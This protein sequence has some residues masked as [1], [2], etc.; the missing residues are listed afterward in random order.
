MV[1]LA[2]LAI[3]IQQPEPPKDDGPR[4]TVQGTFATDISAI[5]G[6]AE[7]RN[8]IPEEGVV[9]EYALGA[10]FHASRGLRI[11]V[12]TCVGCHDFQIQNAFGEAELSESLTLRVG[13]LPVPFGSLSRRVNP[14]QMESSTKPLPYIMGGMVGER[15]FN[16]GIVPAP[17]VDNGAS[18]QASFW[19]GPVQIGGEAAVLRGFKGT[20][21]DIDY[22]VS[23]LF[24]DNNG[25]PAGS[26]RLSVAVGLFTLGISG[27]VG[28]YDVDHDLGYRLA[29]VDLQLQFGT[30]SLRAEALW[31]ETEFFGAGL[32]EH[33]SRRRAYVVE[34]DGPIADRWR[35]FVLHDAMEMR[36]LFATTAGPLVTPGAPPFDEKSNRVFRVAGGAVFSVRPGLQIK[37]S[38]EWWSFDHFKPCAVGHLGVV[39]DF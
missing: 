29:G 11:Q 20:S 24:P 18:I 12:R 32:K 31:R 13:R 4:W 33:V 21:P 37:G 26:G 10:T 14:A 28:T 1:L 2:A 25:E 34:V 22:A 8:T 16:L 9:G 36:G 6:S 23:R 38:V 17:A 35:L 15:A 39:F 7:M 3:L 19:L 5:Y 27:M 30:W